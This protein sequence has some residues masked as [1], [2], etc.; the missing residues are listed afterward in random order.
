MSRIFLSILGLALFTWV[1]KYYFVL[2]Y[3]RK[4]RQEINKLE[5]RAA[6]LRMLLKAKL[7]RKGSQIQDQYKDDKEFIS[8]VMPKLDLLTTFNFNRASDYGDI[9]EIL[10]SLSEQ[11]DMK[12]AQSNPGAYLAQ[13]QKIAQAREGLLKKSSAGTD[14]KEPSGERS[15]Q[16]AETEKSK[17]LAINAHVP[18]FERW[19]QLLKYD[20][21]N[22]YI[23]K[24]I[25]EVTEELK[26]KIDDY[27]IEQDNKELVLRAPDLVEVDGFEG[28]RNIVNMDQQS[29]K[30]NKEAK[31]DKDVFDGG[32]T[33]A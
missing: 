33:A 8:L 9:L 20:K 17:V 2:Y 7:K 13:Q 27:N 24:E 1:A 22:L 18:Q 28:L 32:G 14:K 12:T 19:A 29:A 16:L 21:G 5:A 6:V 26:K 10:T 25:V 11:I 23:I 4:K 31:K 30:A 3:Y 15:V